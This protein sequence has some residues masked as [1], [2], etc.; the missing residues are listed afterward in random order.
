MEQNP[1]E[2]YEILL[3]ALREQQLSWVVEQVQEQ[4]RVGKLVAKDI[5]PYRET[6]PSRLGDQL[7]S[8]RAR[9]T[10]RERLVATEEYSPE[11]RLGLAVD[12]LESAVVHTAEIENEVLGFFASKIDMPVM[13]ISA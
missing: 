9:T 3:R 13:P 4:V 11:E 8:R 2:A 5:T 7:P 12:A 1:E 10:R 6:S